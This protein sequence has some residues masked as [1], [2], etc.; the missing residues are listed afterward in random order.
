V[1]LEQKP[2]AMG[3]RIEHPQPLI[4][5]IQYHLDLGRERPGVLPAARYRLATTVECRSV[6]SFCMCPGGFIVP[7]ATANDEVV[8]NGMSL[9]RR[10]SPYANSGIVVGIEPED[11]VPWQA[12]HGVLAGPALQREVEKSAKKAGGGG[13]VA[14]AQR[15]VDFLRKRE[16]QNLPGTSYFPG[17][18]SARLEKLLPEFIDLRLREGLRRFGKSMKGYLSEEALLV[19]FETRSSS[20]VRIPRDSSSL[21]HPGVA[22]LFP[23]GEGAGYA[24]GIVSAALDGRKCAEAVEKLVR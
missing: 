2:F 11:T 18:R 3:M 8:V 17:V 23:C 19:G 14:P 10:D 20:P 4:D 5:G 6:H 21:Q 7:C 22:G 15:L 1:S 13:Q 12:E 24:G 9:S 16:S